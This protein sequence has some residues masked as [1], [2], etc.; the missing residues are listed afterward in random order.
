MFCCEQFYGFFV[1]FWF[2]KLQ[3]YTCSDMYIPVYFT[4]LSTV[5]IILNFYLIVFDGGKMSFGGD[6][7]RLGCVDLLLG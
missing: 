2:L 7:E 6:Q 3:E 1:W 4:Y 5:L